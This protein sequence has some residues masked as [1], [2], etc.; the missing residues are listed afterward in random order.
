MCVVRILGMI[1]L[2]VYLFFSGLFQVTGMQMPPMGEMLLGLVGMAA[3]VLIL[4]SVGG[5]K[6]KTCS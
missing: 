2:A 6:D 3:G 4:I 5:K 1:F